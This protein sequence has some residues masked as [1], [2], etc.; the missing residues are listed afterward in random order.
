MPVNIRE[1]VI[2]VTIC[3][4]GVGLAVSMDAVWDKAIREAAKEDAAVASFAAATPPR[5]GSIRTW[6]SDG[7]WWIVGDGWGQ[8]HP[9]CP[10]KVEKKAEAELW[11]NQK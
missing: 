9:D 5:N 6:T 11:Q 7:H 3:I 8:H 2:F 4:L 1:A 10:C